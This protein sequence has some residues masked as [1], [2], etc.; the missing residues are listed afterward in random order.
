MD[1]NI[2]KIAQLSFRLP[3]QS[4]NAFVGKVKGLGLDVTDVL[5]AFV[6]S[7]LASGQT[8]TEKGGTGI[9]SR[10]GRNH[11]IGKSDSDVLK[12]TSCTPQELEQVERLLKILRS[13][14]PHLSD[15]IRLNLEQ[16]S[17]LH[18]AWSRERAHDD[19]AEPETG[20]GERGG[21]EGTDGTDD[22]I[23]RAHREIAD[24]TQ[25]IGEGGTAG[26]ERTRP[27]RRKKSKLG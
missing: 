9:T 3:E 20:A 26:D 16:F 19:I 13:P 14:K 17:D 21:V 18:E 4:R 10:V 11:S 7:Y 23:E 25:G 5:F 15:A 24:A 12:L 2:D 8:P 27:R 6:Q 22:F 1:E